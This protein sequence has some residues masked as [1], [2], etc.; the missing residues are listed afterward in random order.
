MICWRKQVQLFAVG[1]K[2]Q[3]FPTYYFHYRP[4]SFLS[5]PAREQAHVS[6]GNLRNQWRLM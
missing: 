3:T 6:E 4:L 5:S 2:H 1:V